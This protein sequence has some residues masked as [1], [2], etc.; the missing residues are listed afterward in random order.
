MVDLQPKPFTTA[1]PVLVS[2]SFTDVSTGT[3]YQDYYLIQ[4]QDSSGAD[5]HLTSQVNYSDSQRILIGGG[6]SS[7]LDYDTDIFPSARTINGDV[8]MSIASF[9]GGSGGDDTTYT[10]KLYSYDGSTET[11]IGETK[12][13]TIEGNNEA[14][15]IYMKNPVTNFII[16]TGSLLRLELAVDAGGASQ[17]GIDPKNTSHGDL[18]ITTT[19]KIVIP[20]KLDL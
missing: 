6:G 2:F 10:M 5:H 14:R 19:S 15:M 8:I 1:S 18:N 9:N 12:T 16:P 7:T 4:S 13:I 20:F 11:Q 17:Y 3:G